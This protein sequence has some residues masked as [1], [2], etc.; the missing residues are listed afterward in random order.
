M[1]TNFSAWDSMPISVTQRAFSETY[2]LEEKERKEA[3]ELNKNYYYG[4]QEND[5]IL[6]N[7]DVNPITMNITKPIM[8]K[9]CSML[10]ARPLV[11]EWDGP[12]SSINFLEEVYKDNKIDS[13][14]GKVDL[15]AELTG[16]VLVH[17]TIDET[18][19]SKIRL[20]IYDATEF[21]SA[22][23]DDDPNTADAL[24][25]TRILS[26]LVDGAPVTS[27]GRKQPQIEKT[28]LQQIWTNDSVTIYEGQDVVVSEPNELGFLPFV[29]FQGEEVHNTYVGYP[30]ATIVRKLNSHI[31]QLLTHIGYTIK[32]QSGTP[33]VFSGFKSGE[34]VVVHP[35][36]AVN[37]PEGATANVLNLDP[38]IN[39]S[40]DF[41]KYLEDRLYTT[42]SVPRISVEGGE[43]QSGRELMVR[44]FPLWKVFQEKSNRYQ[45]YEMQLANMILTIAGYEP[46]NDLKINWAQESIL[47]LS[48]AD[49]NL[50]R[51][52]KLNIVSPID[53][54]MRR[55]PHM[56]EVDAEAEYLTNA[57]QNAMLNQGNQ[58]L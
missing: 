36:R 52:I 27:D 7:D 40:L 32:M 56:S 47:P 51:D 38:K 42:S 15:Y 50:E 19:P 14:L 12:T 21:S 17:P 34:T 49:D 35:G 57:T 26:R 41:I 33:I 28:I 3:A 13:L 54:I 2:N 44:W 46:I 10:Y 48:M 31:N 20:V 8:S 6:M 29:N 18:L 24:A 25:L 1:P 39:E 55:D 22:G 9:R 43:G 5:V 30:I 37:I 45:V 11:R 23:N 16:S 58:V 4:K 53:E